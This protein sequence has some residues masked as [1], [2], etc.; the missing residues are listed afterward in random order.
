MKKVFQFGIILGIAAVSE[1]IN[2]IV[3]LP[4]PASVYGMCILFVLLQTKALRL[5]QVK[6]VADIL[7]RAMPMMFV[8]LCAGLMAQVDVILSIW[9]PLLLIITIGTVIVLVVTGRTT[10]GIIKLER[11]RK[12]E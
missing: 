9:L 8:P 11:R 6:E 12:H 10:Q 4:I 3:P 7:L 2:H 1:L 5:D